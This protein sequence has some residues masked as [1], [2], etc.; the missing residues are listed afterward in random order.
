MTYYRPPCLTHIRHPANPEVQPQ[1]RA[2]R[3]VL[4]QLCGGFTCLLL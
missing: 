2:P 4:G 3:L 1:A